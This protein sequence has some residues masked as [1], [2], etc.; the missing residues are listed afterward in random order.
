[1]DKINIENIFDIH[2][3][4]PITV[5]NVY[6]RRK[7]KKNK[8]VLNIDKIKKNIELKKN[9]AK[10]EYKK[11]FKICVNKINMANDIG[12]TN[13]IYV[14]NNDVFLVSNFKCIDCIKYINNKLIKNKFKTCI[15]SDNSILISWSDIYKNLI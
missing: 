8:T 10:S 9:M 1:M 12:K 13:I 3:E 11:K 2:T 14:V 5:D 6:E 7:S 4:Q 15:L